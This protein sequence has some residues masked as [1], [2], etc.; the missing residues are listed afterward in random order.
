MLSSMTEYAVKALAWLA[1][2]DGRTV[3]VSEIAEKA[4]VPS[5]YLSKI[6]HRLKRKGIVSTQR[7]VGGGVKLRVA[8]SELTL[9]DIAE[10]LEDPI[11]NQRCIFGVDICSDH[12]PCFGN[13]FWAQQHQ[14]A[15]D[16]FKES[17]ITAV[18]LY[19]KDHGGF[20]FH[21]GTCDHQ[22]KSCGGG[23]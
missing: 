1:L 8:P 15:I 14:A 21:H 6:I 20:G 12:Q 7:G 13:E 23:A 2:E 9:F 3:Q 5:A 19:E 4:G 22:N 18:A 11:L 16:F 17:T 10:A